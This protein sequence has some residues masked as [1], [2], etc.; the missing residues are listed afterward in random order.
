MKIE[1]AIASWP[2]WAK[3][4]AGIFIIPTVAIVL[5]GGGFL[6]AVAFAYPPLSWVFEGYAVAFMVFPVAMLVIALA[7]GVLAPMRRRFSRRRQG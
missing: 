4:C 3:V 2:T 6:I 7:V 5:V 1:G